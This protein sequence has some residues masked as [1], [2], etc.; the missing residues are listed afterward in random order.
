M[1]RTSDS[2]ASPT[3]DSVSR[4]FARLTADRDELRAALDLCERRLAALER[5][6]RPPADPADEDP[7]RKA[8]RLAEE[9]LATAQFALQQS[10]R[11]D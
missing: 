3:R 8:L 10:R 4:I 1:S 7:I 2:D 9:A 11:R 5:R 6:S